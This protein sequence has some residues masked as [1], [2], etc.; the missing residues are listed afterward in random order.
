MGLGAHYVL[1][2]GLSAFGV[3]GR[4]GA[5]GFAP[6]GFG[7]EGPTLTRVTVIKTAKPAAEIISLQASTRLGVLTHSD[8]GQVER[9]DFSNPEDPRSTG[10][11]DL[12]MNEGEELTSVAVHPRH[13]YFLACIKGARTMNTGRVQV[14]ALEDGKRLAAYPTGFGPD[15]VYISPDGLYALT[16]N[17]GEGYIEKGGVPFSPPG[18][19]TWLKLSEKADGFELK[20]IPLPTVE[21]KGSVTAKDRRSLER[22]IG[23]KPVLIPIT[24]NTPDCVE[25][26]VIAFAPDGRLAFCTLQENNAV[27]IIDVHSARITRVI[28]LG[29]TRHQADLRNDGVYNASEVLFALR[30]PDGI[31]VLPGGAYFVTAD[32]G[33]T[34]PGPD[35]TAAGQPVGGGRTVSVFQVESGMCVGDTGDQLDRW[36][37]AAG[38]YPDKRSDNKG[39]EPEMITAFAIADRPYAAV[40]LERA[41]AVALIDLSTPEAPRV[42]SLIAVGEDANNFGP[43]GIAH[44]YDGQ[45]DVHYLYTANEVNGTLSV[46]RID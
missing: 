30:E 32:E 1:G 16:A 21:A 28:G 11:F 2:I 12:Q 46:L 45:R 6:K 10:L 35:E 42:V 27:C 33:D 39:S 9:F 20:Q 26:E 23:G 3:M 22:D 41:G 17:E 40:G 36:S 4:S 24:A 25:P 38:I 31:A 8:V 5:E 34:E 37:A 44:L 13:A 7:P 18:S 15:C 29:Y 14:H 43:E 19:L